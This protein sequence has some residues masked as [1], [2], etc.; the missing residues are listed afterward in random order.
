MDLHVFEG[1]VT[2][3]AAEDEAAAACEAVREGYRATGDEAVLT[4]LAD[5]DARGRY[6]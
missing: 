1:S 3:T 4:R 6:R 5:V 2:G